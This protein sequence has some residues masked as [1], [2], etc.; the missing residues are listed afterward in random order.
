[1]FTES[2]FTD[3]IVVG[4]GPT[5]LT[6]GIE[7]ARRGV[8]VRVVERAA[9]PNPGS[10]GDGLQPR[11]LEIFEDVGILD[12]V[13]AEGLLMPPMRAYVGGQFAGERRMAEIEPATPDV[14]YPNGWMLPQNRTEELL[15]A[16]LAE[17]GVEVE[18]GVE[19][20]SFYQDDDG[21]VAMVGGRRVRARYLVGADGGRSTVRRELGIP[22]EGSTDESLRVLLGDVRADELD[23]DYGYWFAPS[24]DP[25]GGVSLT[26]LS[27]GAFQFACPLSEEVADPGLEDL[28]RMFTQRGG[29]A[30]LHDLT[31]HTVWR[32]NTRLA[33]NFRQG[34]V[35]LAGDAAH[36]HPPTGGQ[37]LNTGV[38][39]GYN[40]GWKLAAA[41]AGDVSVLDSYEQERR[42][43]AA[44][45]LGLSTELLDKYRNADADAH[46]RDA[47]TRQLGINYRG[48]PLAIELRLAPGRVQAGDR[49]PDAPVLAPDGQPTRL[50]T[51]FGEPG[52]TLLDFGGAGVS[53]DGART[54][55]LLAQGEPADGVSH[56]DHEGHA[57]A[58]Y[59]VAPR[60]LVLV[61]PDGYVGLVT[62]D[63]ADLPPSV[64]GA[65]RSAPARR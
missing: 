54:V 8:D 9:E 17:L 18:R 53:V 51:L 16:R 32:P 23:H 58:G 3:V 52:W 46:R 39:D 56:V 4:A 61:R 63:P 20:A 15:A 55:P 43:V 42:A 33:R 41:L 1:M 22:F 12:A 45:V 35:F 24:E 37:G 11:T 29:T 57:A 38:G 26:P 28:Q 49:A 7:L 48:G 19:L 14:P 21:V 25:G 65:R 10:R 27:G 44:E 30:R 59:D 6:L 40:L 34:S 36:A 47:S 50:F 2:Q 64:P 60:T 13:L 5:G 62:T 31:W